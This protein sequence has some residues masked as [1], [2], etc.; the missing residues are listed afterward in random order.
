[1]RMKCMNCEASLQVRA[2]AGKIIECP[3]CRTTITVPPVEQCLAVFSR[4]AAISPPQ[5]CVGCLRPRP[6]AVL[7]LPCCLHE[8][9][10][11]EA[12][13]AE[14]VGT[15]LGQ[16]LFGGLMGGVLGGTVGANF[17]KTVVHR[18][19]HVVVIRM[20]ICARC[21]GKMTDAEAA[22][23]EAIASADPPRA[24]T[25]YFT[26]EIQNNHVVMRF[27]NVDYARLF[28]KA[29]AGRATTSTTTAPLVVDPPRTHS[30]ADARCPNT[31]CRSKRG[32]DGL[33]C[34]YCGC[35]AP[36]GES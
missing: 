28:R 33:R 16:G 30:S 8:Q 24:Y 4:S 6:E 15:L 9:V 13:T 19:T 3:K 2:L 20:P 27:E 10:T 35:Q 11:T 18:T 12:S 7:S 23:L 25:P 29:N 36:G 1:M 26:A 21:R 14:K 17:G 22:A 5:L 32:W 34:S 31:S